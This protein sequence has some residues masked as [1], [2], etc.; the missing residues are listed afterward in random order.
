MIEAG[1]LDL[2]AAGASAAA[3]SPELTEAARL[4]QPFPQGAR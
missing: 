4:Q 1:T 3:Y 2:G